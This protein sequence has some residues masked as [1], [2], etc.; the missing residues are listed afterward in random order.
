VGK[1][2]A[3]IMGKEGVDA[4]K[5]TLAALMNVLKGCNDIQITIK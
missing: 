1:S 3:M 5:P 4:S 2:S